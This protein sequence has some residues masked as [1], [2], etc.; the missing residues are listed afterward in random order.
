MIRLNHPTQLL[1]AQ[2]GGI[3]KFI[4]EPFV[5][6]FHNQP[7][8][9]EFM[10][11]PNAFIYASFRKEDVVIGYVITDS[12]HYR[13][14]FREVELDVIRTD[15]DNGRY[16]QIV[17]DLSSDNLLEEFRSISERILQRQYDTK[18]QTVPRMYGLM[19]EI[20]ELMESE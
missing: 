4:N 14:M 13:S 19:V 3:D 9:I 11:D 10:I 18:P 2:F 7:D 8:F 12:V 5:K 1:E 20:Q 16:N 17:T 15:K 6:Q